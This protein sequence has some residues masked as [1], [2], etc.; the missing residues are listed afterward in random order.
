[1][2]GPMRMHGV[3]GA[4]GSRKLGVGFRK[5]QSAALPLLPSAATDEARAASCVVARPCRATPAGVVH[6]TTVKA[7]PSELAPAAASGVVD[8]E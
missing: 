6:S 1:M 5:Q 2:P 4:S 7:K 3:S 8:S